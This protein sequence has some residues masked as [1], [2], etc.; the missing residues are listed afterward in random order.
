VAGGAAGAFAATSMA[1]AA[2][3]GAANP[4]LAGG[5]SAAI[6]IGTPTISLGK[7]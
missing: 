7:P 5:L 6:T 3:H 2:S 1:S 4:G